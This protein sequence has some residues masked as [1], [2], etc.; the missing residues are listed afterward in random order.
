MKQGPPK[1]LPDYLAAVWEDAV[2]QCKDDT[3]PAAVEAL[4]RQIHLMRDAEKRITE[5]G[6]VIVDGKG[7]AT[8]HPGIKIQREA[9]K[10]IRDWLQKY[11][12]RGGF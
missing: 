8:E 12:K 9:G 6:A 3:P 10:E 7:N 11:G 1:S 2:G 4:C 5:D